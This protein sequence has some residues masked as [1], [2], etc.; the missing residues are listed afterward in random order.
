MEMQVC[1]SPEFLEFAGPL[2]RKYMTPYTRN[3]DSLTNE[4]L[5][6]LVTRVKPGY[7]RVDADEL[8]YPAH[9]ILRFEIERDLLEDRWP[10][11]EL[12]AV[13]NDKMKSYLGLSTIG[14]DKD[15]CMQDVHWPGGA[16]GYFPAYTFGAVIAAQLFAKFREGNPGIGGEIASGNFTSL[17][18]WLN[19]NIWSRG[20][21]LRTLDLVEKVAGPLSAMP[22]RAHLENRYG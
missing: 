10:L 20:S 17:R 12:P 3:P 18:G 7:I 22:F 9:V 19:E 1:R 2:I 13:W 14:N 16:F 21:S 5:A 15:G 6:K 4:N 11:S 8:T